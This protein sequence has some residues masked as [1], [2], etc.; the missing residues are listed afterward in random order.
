[1]RKP[2][3]NGAAVDLDA[4][5][6]LAK[7]QEAGYPVQIKGPDGSDLGLTITMAGPDSDRQQKARRR[8]IERR[9][10]AQQL[11]AMTPEQVSDENMT[12][13]AESVIGWTPLKFGGAEL[14]YTPANAV[15]VFKAFPFIYEQVIGIASSRASFLQR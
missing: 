4:F 11:G 1:M 14:P 10:A 13:M 3:I 9:I 8:V 15:K 7:A 12:V 5:S 2:S 6:G